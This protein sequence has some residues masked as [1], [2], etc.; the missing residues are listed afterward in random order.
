MVRN[1]YNPLQVT[2]YSLSPEVIDVMVFCTK[3]PA[4]MFDEIASLSVYDTFWFVTITPYGKD[5][6][7]FVPDKGQ[8]TESFQRLSEIT[9][10]RRVSWRYDPVFISEKYSLEYHI[11][12]FR[13]IAG[14]LKGSTEQCV[15]SFIDLY[16]KTKRNFPDVKA[17]TATEQRY[18]IEVFSQVAAE[19]GLQIHLCCEDSG[20]VMQHVDA[21]GCMS[22]EVLE[23]ALGCRLSVPKKK[24]AR[25]EC[26]CL[27]GADIGAYHTCGHGCLYCY[28]NYDRKTVEQNMKLHDVDSPLLIGHVSEY[29]IVKEAE[30]RSWKDGQMSLFD[31]IQI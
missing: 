22:K 3:N 16:E 19:N 12:Q 2:R 23:H 29:D 17:V 5:I 9:G 27:L 7:P 21:N 15:V 30:Q 13:Q 20:L 25:N 26:E 14:R 10:Y 24:M 1:P 11:E 31:V 6:E 18:L 4:P 28:A 8:V